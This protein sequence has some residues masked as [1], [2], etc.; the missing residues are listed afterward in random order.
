MFGRSKTPTA[1]D[2]GSADSASIVEQLINAAAVKQFDDLKHCFDF[3]DLRHLA[4]LL[5]LDVLTADNRLTVD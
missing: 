4:H 2:P 1:R 5:R 3:S